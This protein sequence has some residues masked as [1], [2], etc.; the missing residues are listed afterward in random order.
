MGGSLFATRFGRNVQIIE[1]KPPKKDQSKC[2]YQTVEGFQLWADF[3]RVEARHRVCVCVCA[4]V[5]VSVCVCVCVCVC[6]S[7]GTA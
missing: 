1:T 7:A 3:T 6:V 2:K 4:R 5:C